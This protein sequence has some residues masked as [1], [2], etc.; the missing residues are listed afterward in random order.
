MTNIDQEKI[1]RLIKAHWEKVVF[2]ILVLFALFH[3]LFW[4]SLGLLCLYGSYLLSLYLMKRI[5]YPLLR[6]IIHGVLLFIAILTVSIGLKM[7]VVDVYKIPSGS[8]RETLLPGDV[9]TVDKLFYGPKLPRSPFE[10]P[11][12]NLL[13]YMNDDARNTIDKNWWP[14]HRLSGTDHIAQGDIVVFQAS[15][16][17]FVVKRCIAVA[18]DTLKIHEGEIYTRNK[19][20]PPPNSV[21]NNFR[22]IAKNTRK[23]NWQI[24]SLSISTV[25]RKDK[26]NQGH[27][28]GVLSEENRKKLE[29]LSMAQ[30]VEK[31]LDTFDIGRG[32]FAMPRGTQWTLDEMGPMTVPKKGMRIVLDSFN[33]DLY[34]KVLQEHEG[35]QLI[36]KET[37]YFNQNGNR[38]DSYTFT[39]DYFFVMGDDRKDSNDSRYIGFVP[40]EQIIGKV[41]HILFSKQMDKIRWKRILKKIH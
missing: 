38:V 22:V 34:K 28:I 33:F 1:F 23:L 6:K 19:V 20:Y 36:E 26:D 2:L 37:G 10:I 21:R 3:G 5:K 4:L 40:T 18:G 9:V 13:F 12:I 8:M 24:D 32:L 29:N 30:S 41:G 31:V 27:F 7:F 39:Q 17:H 11:W 35:I 14:Y 25:L 16:S 15:L